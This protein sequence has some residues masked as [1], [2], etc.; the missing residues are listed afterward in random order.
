ME[1]VF[2]DFLSHVPSARNSVFQL[3]SVLKSNFVGQIRGFFLGGGL[4]G[5]QPSNSN[6]YVNTCK[7][8]E[9][10]SKR[11]DIN[12]QILISLAPIIALFHL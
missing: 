10:G 3:K 12:F 6:T 2:V 8:L 5:L 1:V 7:G 11:D 9:S 4:R